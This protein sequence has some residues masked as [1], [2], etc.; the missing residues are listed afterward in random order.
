MSL[1]ISYTDIEAAAKRLHNVSELTPLL[2]SRALDEACDGQVFVKAESLQHI[3]AFKFRGA[4]NRIVQLSAQERAGGVV[5]WSSGNHAQGVAAA[6]QLLGVKATIVMPADA[7]SIKVEKTRYY[8][9]DIQFYDRY[10][11]DREQVARALC[12]QLSAT[13]VPSYDDP[14]IIAGQGTVGLEITQQLAEPA[15]VLISPCG[16]GGLCSGS[17]MAAKQH[18]PEAEVIGV[19]PELYNDTYLSLENGK[20]E[21]VSQSNTSICDSL[22]AAAPGELTFPINQ[23]YLNRVATVTDEEVEAA[24]YFAWKNLKLVVEPGGAVALAALLA[25][26]VDISGKRCAIILSGG[27]V[28]P[29]WFAKLLTKH[30]A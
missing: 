14:H 13:L 30:G 11:E 18:W 25:K 17:A 21:S 9:A 7:P 20:R 23:Q 8:G 6:A 22:M 15:D 27:N 16:G 3:G 19:E 29:A 5:A 10:S 26:K 4:Y 12:E 1:A 24:V 28:D 2:H